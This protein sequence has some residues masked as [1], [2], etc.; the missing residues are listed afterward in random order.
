M[1]PAT[2]TIM[3]VW[4]AASTSILA[5]LHRN[6]PACRL[7][8]AASSASFEGVVTK[9]P[10]LQ[11]SA[12][13]WCT[14]AIPDAKDAEEAPLLEAASS[15]WGSRRWLTHRLAVTV[16]IKAWVRFASIAAAVSAN[17]IFRDIDILLD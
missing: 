12:G 8:A 15:S 9:P 6:Q 10:K 5:E 17:S 4:R 11:S 13:A 16:C 14:S 2:T 3:L 7:R 1:S